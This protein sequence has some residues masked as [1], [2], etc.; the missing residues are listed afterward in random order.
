M[1][2]VYICYTQLNF[3]YISLVH[4][5]TLMFSPL[6]MLFRLVRHWE[7]PPRSLR[8]IG[9]WGT[10]FWVF[11][12]LFYV[13]MK[14]IPHYTLAH[15]TIAHVLNYISWPLVA[16]VH[17]CG[18]ARGPKQTAYAHNYHGP[19]SRQAVVDQRAVSDCQYLSASCSHVLPHKYGF[20]ITL[21]MG[22]R[23]Y[24]PSC[25]CIWLLLVLIIVRQ[26]IIIYISLWKRTYSVLN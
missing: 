22:R 9:S 4:H 11:S 7:Y 12:K 23:E 10:D 6:H 21:F 13:A 18:W 14:C 17:E 16:S 19:A 24:T 25:L 26:H 1:P 8:G 20:Q 3:I 5:T 15:Q 2:Y